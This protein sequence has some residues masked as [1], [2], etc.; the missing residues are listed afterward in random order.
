[1]ELGEGKPEDDTKAVCE[2]SK[3]DKI[4]KLQSLNSDI[5]LPAGQVLIDAKD[6]IDPAAQGNLITG[7]AEERRSKEELLDVLTEPKDFNFMYKIVSN[8]VIMKF[9]VT[10]KPG[11]NV[12]K[13]EVKFGFYLHIQ[14]KRSATQNLEVK[15]PIMV[16]TGKLKI[17]TSGGAYVSSAQ[18]VASAKKITQ[19]QKLASGQAQMLDHSYISHASVKE[20][21]D[22]S[23]QST[24][25]AMTGRTTQSQA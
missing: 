21:M 7:N 22:E 20:R 13:D 12:E 8:N 19:E 23:F 16:N 6:I 25:T 14:Q 24:T 3:E 2:I 15:V 17:N 1:M 5:D 9:P 11:F 4:S 18:S 10:L